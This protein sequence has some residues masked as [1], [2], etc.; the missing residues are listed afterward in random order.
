MLAWG[1]GPGPCGVGDAHTSPG[2]GP[3]V[4][5][6]AC[7][8][9]CWLG[10][11]GLG[12]VALEVCIR[13]LGPGLLESEGV[14]HPPPRTPPPTTD[15]A[16][17]LCLVCSTFLMPYGVYY[18]QLRKGSCAIRPSIAGCL[19]CPHMAGTPCKQPMLTTRTQCAPM[20]LT[21]IKAQRGFLFSTQCGSLVPQHA[22]DSL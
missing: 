3:L 2:P 6:I 11:L 14:P 8:R 15:H 18:M 16:Y 13:A 4:C 10:A 5:E 12:L 22:R 7:G 1:P 21:L 20:R 9:A 19:L 17:C